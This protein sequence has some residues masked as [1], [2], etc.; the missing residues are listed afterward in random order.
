MGQSSRR[1]R[2]FLLGGQVNRVRRRGRS[3][4]R[5][6]HFSKLFSAT[7]CSVGIDAPRGKLD[8]GTENVGCAQPTKRVTAEGARGTF[9]KI[10]GRLLPVADLSLVTSSAV[11]TTHSKMSSSAIGAGGR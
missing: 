7:A 1:G 5:N 6:R 2:G 3:A 8:T 10:E 9:G 11:L 4:G